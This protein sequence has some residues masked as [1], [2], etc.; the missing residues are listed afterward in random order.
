MTNH[1]PAAATVPE[2]VSSGSHVTGGAGADPNAVAL[3]G[4]T[5]VITT[6]LDDGMTVITNLASRQVTYIY[7]H[8]SHSGAA[9]PVKNQSPE[10]GGSER[11]SRASSQATT[12]P[13]RSSVGTPTRSGADIRRSC[14]ARKEWKEQMRK[15]HLPAIF[16]NEAFQSDEMAEVPPQ[17]ESELQKLPDVTRVSRADVTA[18]HH[19]DGGG[20]GGGG[21]GG[22]GRGGGKG[23][24]DTYFHYYM[25]SDFHHDYLRS[26]SLPRLESESEGASFQYDDNDIEGILDRGPSARS[27]SFHPPASSSSSHPLSSSASS[28]HLN[29]FAGDASRPD[30]DADADSP[31][32]EK[33]TSREPQQQQQ[34]HSMQ[35]AS[36]SEDVACGWDSGSSSEGLPRGRRSSSSIKSD[37]RSAGSDSAS[38]N[39]DP[40]HRKP[41]RRRGGGA[42]AGGVAAAAALR[43]GSRPSL[44]HQR[45]LHSDPDVVVVGGGTPEDVAGDPSEGGKDRVESSFY[46]VFESV[47][48]TETPKRGV[49]SD[50]EGG[51]SDAPDVPEEF[52]RGGADLD[53]AVGV[54]LPGGR[55]GEGSVV[56]N[57]D[58]EAVPTTA[59]PF[60]DASGLKTRGPAGMVDSGDVFLS[61]DNVTSDATHTDDVS[62]P[63]YGPDRA[64]APSATDADRAAAVVSGDEPFRPQGQATVLGLLLEGGVQIPANPAPSEHGV[65]VAEEASQ[66]DPYGYDFSDGRLD[67]SGGPARAEEENGNGNTRN[68]N[69]FLEGFHEGVEFEPI[70]ASSSGS[71]LLSPEEEGQMTRNNL[72]P[73]TNRTAELPVDSLDDAGK[74][75]VEKKNKNNSSSSSSV[76]AAPLEAGSQADHLMI[77]RVGSDVDAPET[78]VVL[79]IVETGSS[80]SDRSVTLQPYHGDRR[81]PWMDAD[82]EDEGAD[83]SRAASRNPFQPYTFDGRSSEDSDVFGSSGDFGSSFGSNAELGTIFGNR[84]PSASG[85]PDFGNPFSYDSFS[86]KP[87]EDSDSDFLQSSGSSEQLNRRSEDSDSGIAYPYPMFD[88]ETD[89][90]FEDALALEHVISGNPYYGNFGRCFESIEEEPEDFSESLS[91]SLKGDG[92]VKFRTTVVSRPTSRNSSGTELS[93]SNPFQ[94]LNGDFVSQASQNSRT[95]AKRLSV[96]PFA[97]DASPETAFGGGDAAFFGHSPPGGDEAVVENGDGVVPVLSSSSDSNAKHPPTVRLTRPSPWPSVDDDTSEVGF[98]SDFSKSNSFANQGHYSGNEATSG[99]AEDVVVNELEVD[100]GMSE[101]NHAVDGFEDVATW[102]VGSA[103]ARKPPVAPRPAK[104]GGV[105][106]PRGES[107][108]TSRVDPV[109]F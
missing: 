40:G 22:G 49:V 61:L 46:P 13:S 73:E 105:A 54:A 8:H 75:Q 39:T 53:A 48:E 95:P 35:S 31:E 63:V 76:G 57:N 90:G 79:D 30:P 19:D 109:Y 45:T 60:S 83:G 33:R 70:S 34:Q 47:A 25:S 27:S 72:E 9:S 86:G 81:P 99:A 11:N 84:P 18:G 51:R 4:A 43:Q 44:Q 37:T 3:V 108:T 41:P 107:V 38:Q 94:V 77:T 97:L 93:E 23:D 89:R 64:S 102:E 101:A 91:S 14:S 68:T 67:L 24:D 56:N 98:D 21:R 50:G 2:T 82:F 17:A 65:V 59:N 6:D 42:A 87:L 52:D 96:N 69:P 78:A 20:G 15:K 80:G 62:G 28:H 29:S 58:L 106:I 66:P 32:L 1:I 103:A 85:R 55:G 74:I 16:I 71:R 92:G 5:E 26:D 36:G 88:E 10:G 100:P 12:S 104:N 7:D